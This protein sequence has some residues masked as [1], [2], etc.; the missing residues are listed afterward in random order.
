[1]KVEF[2]LV[3]F[4]VG[5]KSLEQHL[6]H[7]RCLINS[8]WL[9]EIKNMYSSYVWIELH[10]LQSTCA[11]DLE[12]WPGDPSRWLRALELVGVR[13]SCSCRCLSVCPT[14]VALRAS[15]VLT[16]GQ[17]HAPGPFLEESYQT[18]T[19]I[20]PRNHWLPSAFSLPIREHGDTDYF[21]RVDKAVTLCW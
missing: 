19:I 16:L 9:N 18:E 10:S 3:F 1:M 7:S 13:S 21:H 20:L 4:T 5:S 2:L 15:G 12:T 17:L 14:P 8:S 11:V 6:A